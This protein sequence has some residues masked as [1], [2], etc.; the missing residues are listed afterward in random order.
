MRCITSI[1]RSELTRAYVCSRTL[2]LAR[3]AAADAAAVALAVNCSTARTRAASIMLALRAS[4]SR[5]D[6]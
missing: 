3:T 4:I 5:V 2:S 1:S 6:V